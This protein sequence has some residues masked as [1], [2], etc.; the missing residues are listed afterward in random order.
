MRTSRIETQRV[1][2]LS[3]SDVD[4][5]KLKDAIQSVI[6]KGTDRK[7]RFEVA[8]WR[9]LPTGLDGRSAQYTIDNYL[10]DCEIVIAVF[11]SSVG[12]RF[13]SEESA[14]VHEINNALL[15]RIRRR[16]A[17]DAQRI[18]LYFCKSEKLAGQLSANELADFA[19]ILE[20]KETFSQY[21]L[22]KEYENEKS[23]LENIKEDFRWVSEET[24]MNAR[25]E[26]DK[27]TAYSSEHL[28]LMEN[29]TCEGVFAWLEMDKGY[30]ER[31]SKLFE[32]FYYPNG[33]IKEYYTNF[34]FNY[35]VLK[36]NRLKLLADR[37]KD[38]FA[39]F[40]CN[41]VDIHLCEKKEKEGGLLED[42][43]AFVNF[44]KHA[45]IIDG[46]AVQSAPFS[47]EL[48]QDAYGAEFVDLIAETLMGG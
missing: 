43:V 24:V 12:S 14:T 5:D 18:M 4:R 46:D 25:E 22:H 33:E 23:L 31:V 6:H 29:L 39:Y 2:L 20:I 3:P 11:C 44:I 8:E 17:K 45:A 19:K 35:G 36:S 42:K 38:V 27:A 37:F 15:K 28:V 26:H 32:K 10:G 40:V 1:A 34:V 48:I 9:D 21:G 16:H 30:S 7:L 47:F 13:N 41:M